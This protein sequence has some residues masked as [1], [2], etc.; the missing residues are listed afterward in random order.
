VLDGGRDAA[1]LVACR[2]DD[3]Q[4]LEWRVTCHG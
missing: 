1:F 2:N 3:R 4:E